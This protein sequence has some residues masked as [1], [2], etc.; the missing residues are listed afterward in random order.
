MKESELRVGMRV[1]VPAERVHEPYPWQERYGVISHFDYFLGV[2]EI[3]VTLDGE[4]GAVIPCTAAE[5]E[6]E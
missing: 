5:L 2:T 6:P 3:S 1:M 4:S